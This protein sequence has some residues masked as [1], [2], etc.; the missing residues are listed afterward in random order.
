MHA[1]TY[2]FLFHSCVSRARTLRARACSPL[3]FCMAYANL[4]QWAFLH[5]WRAQPEMFVHFLMFNDT[6][7]IFSL[8][9]YYT[10]VSLTSNIGAVFFKLGTRNVHHKRNRM[11]P[12]MLLPW[13]HFWLQSLSV[14]NHICSFA[15]LWKGTEGLAR[16]TYS[17][18]FPYCLNSPH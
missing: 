8:T 14:K 13:Q 7:K 18:W 17:V 11:K 15:T 2:K 16:N 3:G 1:L 12:S 10:H 9:F 6:F 5:R 4:P